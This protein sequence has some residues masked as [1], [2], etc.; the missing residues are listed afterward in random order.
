MLRRNQDA[1]S[2]PM[3]RLAPFAA[4]L[5]LAASAP[6]P[7]AILTDLSGALNSRDSSRVLACFT[8]D[9][10]VH[11]ARV[12]EVA[13]GSKGAGATSGFSNSDRALARFLKQRA[14]KLLAEAKSLDAL[15]TLASRERDD[16]NSEIE[17]VQVQTVETQPGQARGLLSI[18]GSPTALVL[19]LKRE[20]GR[21]RIH[22]VSSPLL[23]PEAVR[24]SAALLGISE[25]QAIDD[26]VDRLVDA[27]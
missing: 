24:L 17:R 8:R 6:G 14:P 7:G 27:R 1:R 19:A 26:F 11:Y 23:A 10:R 25:E 4:L 2:R 20:E 5:L 15:A 12:L 3:K 16:W 22:R 18:D 13:R 9:A 21:W